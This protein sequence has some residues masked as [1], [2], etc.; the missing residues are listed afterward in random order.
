MRELWGELKKLARLSTLAAAI[1][2]GIFV[3][4]L[5]SL[6][7]ASAAAQYEIAT[8]SYDFVAHPE[9]EESLCDFV[10]QPVGP[11]CDAAARE[12]LQFAERFMEETSALYPLASAAVDPLG[13]GGIVAGFMASLVGLL[14]VAGIAGAHVGGEWGHG[15]VKQVLA[16]DPSRAKFFLLKVLSVWI[17]AVALLLAAWLVVAISSI[18][19]KDW[20]TVPPPPSGTDLASFTAQQITRG[21]LVVAVVAVLATSV[22]V[23]VRGAIGTL[24]VTAGIIVAAFVATASRSTFRLS[25]AYWV[26][27]WMGFEPSALWR[28]HLWVDRFPLI[29]PDASLVPNRSVALAALVALAAV[30]GAISTIY[31]ARRDV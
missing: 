23:F 22:A 1:G 6:H 13:S 11:K 21:L 18:V 28:D 19:M 4:S 25:P 15:T 9:S 10:A 12:E 17:A 2:W 30:L 24:S 29:D 16:V 8:T 3:G 20:Y 26:A 7:V 5:N 27:A 14:I 31:L